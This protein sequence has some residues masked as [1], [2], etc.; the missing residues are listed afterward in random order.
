MLREMRLNCDLDHCTDASPS[1]ILGLSKPVN[2]YMKSLHF[3]C[4]ITLGKVLKRLQLLR[5][6][7][8]KL[9]RIERPTVL[10]LLRVLH[11]RNPVR[12]SVAPKIEASSAG[13]R[14]SGRVP[15]WL[16]L[17]GVLLRVV[18]ASGDRVVG[19]E[20]LDDLVEEN[21]GSDSEGDMACMGEVEV[22]STSAG[23]S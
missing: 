20:D 12:R 3:I 21:I 11:N 4:V 10:R 16:L 8:V 13:T 9:P 14:T 6:L 22:L 23:V 17:C 15:G 18:V 5:Q 19:T 2:F 1:Q 7:R